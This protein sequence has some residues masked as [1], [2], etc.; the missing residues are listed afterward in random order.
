[1]Q[2][3]LPS[4]PQQ[5]NVEFYKPSYNVATELLKEVVDEKITRYWNPN[6]KLSSEYPFTFSFPTAAGDGNQSYTITI[7]GITETGTPIHKS[8]QYNL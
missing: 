8:F 6:V 2:T 4:A 5:Q 1:M 3:L 7:E